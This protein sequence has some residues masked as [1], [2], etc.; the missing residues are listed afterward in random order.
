MS[1]LTEQDKTPT[2]KFRPSEKQLDWLET[3]IR[4]MTT[5]PKA[6]EQ[7]SQASRSA[8]YLWLKDPGFEDWYFEEYR[9]LR[10]RFL[11]TL[12]EIGM[13]FAKQGNH[14]FWRDMNKKAGEDLDPR[15]NTQAVQV[16][17]QQHF[18]KEKDEFE[19]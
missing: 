6:I 5:S 18:T 16:N 2:T 7:E 11:P 19:L 14:D 10:R 9:K 3:S 17:I 13:K 1:N 15:S 4:L 8:W 12:D